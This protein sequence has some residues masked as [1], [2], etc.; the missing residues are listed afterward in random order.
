M[1]VA[2]SVVAPEAIFAQDTKAIARLVELARQKGSDNLNISAMCESFGLTRPS[3]LCLAYELTF[4]EP[5]FYP[6]FYVVKQPSDSSARIILNNYNFKD[7]SGS[8]WQ[9]LTGTDGVLQQ[10]RVGYHQAGG[11]S[12][13]SS[14]SIS[15]PGVRSSFEKEISYW[16]GRLRNL[17]A[18]PKLR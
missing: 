12:R 13:W 15:D 11:V 7:I 6:S 9:Y 3:E 10:A 5:G 8:T 17:E 4:D 16:T 14:A 18:A 1:L 2:L